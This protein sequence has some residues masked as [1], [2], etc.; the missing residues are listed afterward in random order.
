MPM[1]GQETEHRTLGKNMPRE[2]LDIQ[3]LTLPI[4][5]TLHNPKGLSI[6]WTL[7]G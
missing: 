5:T 2:R 3:K 4:I 6:W 7:N 1:A